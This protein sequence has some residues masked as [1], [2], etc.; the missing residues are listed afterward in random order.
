MPRPSRLLALGLLPLACADQPAT[1][2]VIATNADRTVL[3]R[4]DTLRISARRGER[5]WSRSYPLPSP[6]VLPG[7]LAFH[8]EDPDDLPG[9]ALQVQISG[10]QGQDERIRRVA[11]VRFVKERS[12][13]LRLGLTANCLAEVNPCAG[14]VGK[15]CEDGR[16]IDEELPEL[17]EFESNE[18]ATEPEKFPGLTGGMGGAGAAGEAGQGGAGMGGAGMGGSAGGGAAGAGAA[19]GP[20]CEGSLSV[21]LQEAPV[22]PLAPDAPLLVAASASGGSGVYAFEI[23]SDQGE[24]IASSSG[25]SGQVVKLEATAQL[26]GRTFALRVRDEGCPGLEAAPVPLSFSVT[27]GTWVSP[28]CA[29]GVALECGT[30]ERPWCSIQAAQQA[31]A[32]SAAASQSGITLRLL[33]GEK[34][35]V[36]P[37]QMVHQVHLEG[38]YPADFSSM[39]PVN[40]ALSRIVAA[41]SD[42]AVRWAQASMEPTPIIADLRHVTVE[43]PDQKAQQRRA[44]WAEGAVIATLKE[45]QVPAGSEGEG[46]GAALD[47]RGAGAKISIS[48]GSLRGPLGIPGAT[49]ALDGISVEGSGHALSLNGVE[50]I[51]GSGNAADCSGLRFQGQGSGTLQV[52]GG[53][54]IGSENNG[55]ARATGL[56]LDGLAKVS[57]RGSLARGGVAS[58][59]AVG[60]LVRGKV[61]TGFLLDG[62]E[63]TGL[64]DGSGE[65]R[66]VQLQDMELPQDSSTS[67]VLPMLGVELR[68]AIGG[69]PA[70]AVGL[71]TAWVRADAGSGALEI[72]V[73]LGP[74]AEGQRSRVIGATGTSAAQ[75]AVGVLADRPQ[76]GDGTDLN[77]LAHLEVIDS[78]IE[79]GNG[80]ER[81]GAR[82]ID[83]GLTAKNA[84]F[85]GAFLPG[86]TTLRG[87]ELRGE[88]QSPNADIEGS[89]IQ[90]GEAIS[91]GELYTVAGLRLEGSSGFGK[92][93][94]TTSS[95][96]GCASGCT[97]PGTA[98]GLFLGKV[99]NFSLAQ[100]I[101]EAGFMV[102]GDPAQGR[103]VGI[104]IAPSLP[105][106]PVVGGQIL[107]EENTRIVGHTINSPLLQSVGV[108]I[109]S[110]PL[111]LRNNQEISGGFAQQ[112]SGIRV[113]AEGAFAPASGVII[114]RNAR[115]FGG[116][117][118]SSS[119]LVLRDAIGAVVQGNRVDALGLEEGKC[120][121]ELSL[122]QGLKAGW[123]PDSFLVNNLFFGGKNCTA[124]ACDIDTLGPVPGAPEGMV[125]AHNLCL[126]PGNVTNNGE[127]LAIGIRALHRSQGIN[128]PFK[129]K[130]LL[131]RANLLAV[132]P[133]STSQVLGAKKRIVGE[134][135]GNQVLNTS[136]EPLRLDH[137]RFLLQSPGSNDE[138]VLFQGVSSKPALLPLVPGVLLPVDNGE[139]QASG[140]MFHLPEDGAP[141]KEPLSYLIGAT[142]CEQSGLMFSNNL[143]TLGG[144]LSSEVN[145]ALLGALGSDIELQV[146]GAQVTAGPDE[147]GSGQV[148]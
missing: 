88:K 44:L 106:A 1:S 141:L 96:Q 131:V 71:D 2:L 8:P 62:V 92:V 6:G 72:R 11:R 80:E 47:I 38:G 103:F 29:P 130:T 120:S 52:E 67:F 50:L 116:V 139:V 82:V 81:V 5:E 143:Q 73:N 119:G 19:G 37:V 43:I 100:S 115:I 86:G 66:G 49:A 78:D 9:E 55:A 35:F 68:G 102:G 109:G 41:G 87:L 89:M 97:G 101:V 64:L 147:C 85:L 20:S 118:A 146:R 84:L 15:T 56:R 122:S 33:A 95:L 108:Q 59:A 83:T 16:C 105:G 32:K 123:A 128:P 7:T 117:G 107:L 136:L 57:V 17:P 110:G 24:L 127:S 114:E 124:I 93:T 94:V 26:C 70:Q 46:R 148:P 39:Q 140:V 126:A 134:F 98:H 99:T 138:S 77:T 79:G 14:L 18:E 69:S 90:G 54:L 65:G 31:L 135:Q 51:G 12:K 113:E 111:V 133:S 4:I 21:E 145:Q 104:E 34:P 144:V 58:K 30:R 48:G 63:A 22:G 75:S 112:T 125:F 132:G 42:H 129:H 13:L 76:K 28:D 74:S 91:P 3:E 27:Q 61:P 53:A 45:V 25:T 10:L 60:V 121:G 137:N 23:L 142:K 36:G 40:G